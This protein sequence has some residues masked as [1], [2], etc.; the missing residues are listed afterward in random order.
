MKKIAIIAACGA[1]AA[2]SAPAQAADI[3]ANHQTVSSAF[4]NA[5]PATPV[6][7]FDKKKKYR[8]ANNGRGNGKYDNN[9]RYREPRRISRN[10]R[11]W[12]GRDGK[13]YCQRDNGTT[14]LL[15]GAGVGGLAGNQVAGSGDKALGTVLGA[16]AGGL[17]GRAIDRDDVKCR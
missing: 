16:V 5:A 2:V 15:I 4:G 8:K 6:A 10:D 7:Q 17:L 13:Y 12:R 14:G 1:L 3:T 11:V 9:G